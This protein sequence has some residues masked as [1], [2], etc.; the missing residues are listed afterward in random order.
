MQ[1]CLKKFHHNKSVFI[2]LRIQEQ[3]SL[4]KL[5][6]LSHYASSIQLFSTTDNY[7][8]EQTDC[9]HIDFA[10]DAYRTTNHKNE[11]SQMTKWLEHRERI[12]QLSDFI[13]WILEHGEHQSLYQDVMGPARVGALT[14]KMA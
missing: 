9:L 7:N 3:F 6:S 14:L 5:H 4:P 10:K 2:D 13:N 12:Q 1:D 11:Y 8:T